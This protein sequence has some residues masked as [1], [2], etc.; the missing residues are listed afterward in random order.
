MNP[1]KRQLRQRMLEKRRQLSDERIAKE[2]HAVCESIKMEG[3]YRKARV[4][5]AYIPFRNELDIRPLL[6]DAWNQGKRIVV[7]KSDPRSRKMTLIEIFHLQELEPGAYGILEPPEVPE[8]IV[9]PKEVDLAVV[10][11]VAFDLSGYRLGYGGGYYDHFFARAGDH[12]VRM[13]VAYSFQQ[14]ASVFP[15]KHDQPLHIV[16][17]PE[18]VW[19]FAQT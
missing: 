13:G 10:P 11:L 12:L 1:E 3:D 2:S 9:G 17:T 16:V 5:F 7:P 18:R 14:A 8:R 15:E 19:R 6:K 4:V